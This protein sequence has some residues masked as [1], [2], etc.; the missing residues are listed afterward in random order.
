MY[1]SA[2]QLELWLYA[3]L[4]RVMPPRLAQMQRLTPSD[5]SC[6]LRGCMERRE[7]GRLLGGVAGVHHRNLYV[8]AGH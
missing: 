6:L 5:D 4:E 2:L 8:V 3:L 1:H 7:D